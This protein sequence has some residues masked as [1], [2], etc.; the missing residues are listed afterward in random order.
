MN[1]LLFNIMLHLTDLK[2]F[3]CINKLANQLYHDSFFWK[4]KVNISGSGYEIIRAYNK[5]LSLTK[6]FSLKWPINYVTDKFPLYPLYYFP[7]E[8]Y[9]Y[10]DG[11]R[12][13]FESDIH[14]KVYFIRNDQVHLLFIICDKAF[15]TSISNTEYIILLTNIFYHEPDLKIY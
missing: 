13:A 1:D 15:S 10:Y 14:Y 5:A 8:V 12:G 3:S 2:S 7:N 9:H 6:D 11:I 4:V